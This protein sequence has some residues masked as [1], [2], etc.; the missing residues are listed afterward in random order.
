MGFKQ[1]RI[2]HVSISN[3]PNTKKSKNT[4]RDIEKKII[5]E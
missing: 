3:E 4:V 2:A 5:I 1:L